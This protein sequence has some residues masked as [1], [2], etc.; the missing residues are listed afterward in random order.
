M[1]DSAQ[2]VPGDV[3]IKWRKQNQI[4]H[5]EWYQVNVH[6][7]NYKLF[8]EQVQQILLKS[9]QINSDMIT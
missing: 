7:E 1:H 4:Q 5:G 6:T 9:I 2:D 3:R 8:C